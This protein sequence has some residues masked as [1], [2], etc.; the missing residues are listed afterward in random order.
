[1]EDPFQSGY[2]VAPKR[3]SCSGLNLAGAIL[4]LAHSI[5]SMQLEGL[6]FC[7]RQI[8]G[9]RLPALLQLTFILGWLTVELKLLMRKIALHVLRNASVILRCKRVVMKL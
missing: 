7:H 4:A 5:D 6:R 1:M 3:D 9:T 8:S 2:G